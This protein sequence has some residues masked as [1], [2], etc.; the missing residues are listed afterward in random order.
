MR[1]IVNYGIF[2]M[3]H[4]HR[5]K[6]DKYLL[7]IML[8]INVGNIRYTIVGVCTAEDG[9]LTSVDKYALYL[10]WRYILHYETRV[11]SLSVPML[12]DHRFLKSV[13]AVITRDENDRVDAG[14]VKMEVERIANVYLSESGGN[15]SR[16]YTVIYIITAFVAALIISLNIFRIARKKVDIQKKDRM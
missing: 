9:V 2:Y 7:Y 10:P 12:N 15:I 14:R 11:S 16:G 6:L 4:K 5:F 1:I 3:N 13:K 8:T